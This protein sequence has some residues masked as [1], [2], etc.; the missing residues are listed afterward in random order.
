MSTE[1]YKCTDT[2]DKKKK[3]RVPTSLWF[4]A[5]MNALSHTDKYASTHLL[6][7]EGARHPPPGGNCLLI[8]KTTNKWPSA[9]HTIL[10]WLNQNTHRCDGDTF[11]ESKRERE[12]RRQGKSK[13]KATAARWLSD[14]QVNTH[15]W[16][17]SAFSPLWSFQQNNEIS[18]CTERKRYT[19][20]QAQMPNE[21]VYL[22][23]MPDS[24]SAFI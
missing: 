12:M 8:I 6:Q 15:K 2:K 10:E 11:T 1:L 7:P 20:K 13:V 5:F 24:N 4:S 17:F 19:E 14:A 16:T 23:R 3:K 18:V 21:Q 22:G 9:W